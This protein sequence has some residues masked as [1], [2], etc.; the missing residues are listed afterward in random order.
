M[1]LRRPFADLSNFSDGQSR[2]VGSKDTVFWN[3]SLSLLQNLVLNFQ[4]FKH[5][6]N[7][8]VQVLEPL[9]ID[10]INWETSVYMQILTL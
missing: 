5:S 2:G 8:H 3:D 10:T 9:V 7:H 1:Y 6:F 4:V